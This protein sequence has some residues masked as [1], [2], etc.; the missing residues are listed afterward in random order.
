MKKEPQLWFGC[1]KCLPLAFK[2]FYP[3]THEKKVHLGVTSSA[4]VVRW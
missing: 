1:G 2:V 4:D 3:E